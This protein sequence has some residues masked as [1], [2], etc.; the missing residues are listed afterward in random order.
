MS[1]AIP[2][3]PQYALMVWCSVEAQ[4][5][6]YLLFFKALYIKIYNTVPLPF[7]LCG[8]EMCS[9]K[10]MQ[11]DMCLNTKRSRKYMDLKGMKDLE[12]REYYIMERFVICMSPNIDVRVG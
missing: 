1:G 4:G 12:I 5:Q 8:C 10:L 3:F 11:E 2:P 9:R 7:I 6:L